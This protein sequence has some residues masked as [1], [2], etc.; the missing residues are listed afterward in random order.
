MTFC[1]QLFGL[2][3]CTI[4][5]TIVTSTSEYLV[6]NEILYACTSLSHKCQNEFSKLARTSYEN[7]L[8]PLGLQ[9]SNDAFELQVS[10]TDEF[11]SWSFGQ[12]KPTFTWRT[13]GFPDKSL[14][15][16]F[17]LGLDNNQ[18]KRNRLTCLPP[19]NT[20][21][22]TLE[23]IIKDIQMIKEMPPVDHTALS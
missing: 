8:V 19:Q 7:L 23:L 4:V 21:S 16:T 6:E 18:N 20:A 17:F 13:F 3:Q 22:C 5:S 15:I 12:K 10:E 9:S 2:I 14:V 1:V 11:S